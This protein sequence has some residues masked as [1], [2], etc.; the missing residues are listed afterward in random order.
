MATSFNCHVG[1]EKVN[2]LELKY[3]YWT[4]S[5]QLQALAVLPHGKWPQ[6]LTDKCEDAMKTPASEQRYS[7]TM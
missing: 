2:I 4:V 1:H 7:S 3:Q 5:G 6:H